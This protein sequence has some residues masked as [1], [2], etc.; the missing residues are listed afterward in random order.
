MTVGTDCVGPYLFTKSLLPIL[1]QTARL[2]PPGSV[3]VTWA[4]SIALEVYSPPDGVAFDS[5]GA[6]IIHADR[7]ANYG[8]AKAGNLF[9]G[10]ELAKRCREDGIVSVVRLLSV[11]V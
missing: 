7:W 1:R 3:R 10:V 5:D 4:G 11:C 9:L 6:A 2:A 8:Q